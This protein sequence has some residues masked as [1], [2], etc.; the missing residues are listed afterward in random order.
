MCFFLL[1]LTEGFISCCQ[2]L[3]LLKGAWRNGV[4]LH[5]SWPETGCFHQMFKPVP[6]SLLA[7]ASLFVLTSFSPSLSDK[8]LFYFCCSRAL[9]HLMCSTRSIRSDGNKCNGIGLVWSLITGLDPVQEVKWKRRPYDPSPHLQGIRLYSC[10]LLCW[11]C[12]REKQESGPVF[13]I[14]CSVCS[15]RRA[16]IE[17]PSNMCELSSL[18]MFSKSISDSGI[19]KS[20]A[21][22][23]TKW[24]QSP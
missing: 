15:S 7:P 1:F 24:K 4:K 12:W 8:S 16:D 18:F 3:N 13:I 5:F 22:C 10:L 6:T 2:D 20:H 19:I 14:G 9:I 21:V 17:P 11:V 23:T